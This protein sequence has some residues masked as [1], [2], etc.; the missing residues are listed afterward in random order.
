MAIA[1]DVILFGISFDAMYD[2]LDKVLNPFLECGITLNKQKCK[3]F[4]N[5]VEFFGFVFS[6]KDMT[7][8]QTKTESIQNMPPSTNISELR[9]FLC[10]TYYLSRYKLLKSF[11]TKL[12]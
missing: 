12:F 2:T 6:E 11:C 10:M 8:S 7:P 1:D 5:K 9:S 4:I 3:L